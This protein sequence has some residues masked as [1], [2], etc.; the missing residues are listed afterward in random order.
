MNNFV[1][2]AASTSDG[3][4]SNIQRFSEKGQK[5]VDVARKNLMGVYN[6]YMGD[7]DLG[8]EKVNKYRMDMRGKK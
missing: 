6:N 3:V 2:T 8:D 5:M 4:T 1:I 7:M